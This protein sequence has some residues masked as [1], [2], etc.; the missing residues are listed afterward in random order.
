MAVYRRQYQPYVGALTRERLRFLV[1]PRYA[2]AELLAS[3]PLLIFLVFT[4]LPILAEGVII[5]LAHS[6]AARALLGI[7]KLGDFAL[8]NTKF[9]A[10]ALS[11]QCFFGFIL[12]AWVGPGLVAPDLANGALPLYLSRPFSRAEYVLGKA[13]VL[14]VL[15][16]VVTWVPGL[17]L[18]LVNCAFAESGWGISHLRIAFTLVA[19]SLAW[20]AVVTLF[21]LALSAWIKWR[22]AASAMLF[23][24]YFVGAGIG[25]TLAVVLRVSWGRLFN[26]SHL[27]DVVW[28]QLFGASRDSQGVRPL[29]A[30]LALS[31]V[32]VFS[33]VVL[34]RRLRAREVA[35]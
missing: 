14:V 27:F 34:N 30:W 4:M 19:G 11:T 20:T 8:I 12:A 2:I 15:L 26:A 31:G 28:A 7:A 17:L 32:C 6:A 35:R 21:S 13:T 5:Y 10:S 33:L 24:I 16:S 29:V 1:L 22:L 3:R 23:G 25:E 18:Y 9:F